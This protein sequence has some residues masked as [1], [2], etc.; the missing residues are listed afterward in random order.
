MHD[1]VAHR[2]SQVSMRAGALAYRD[3]LS[4]DQMRAESEI[5][6]DA[7]NEALRELR[8]VLQVLR[9]PSSGA[10]IDHPQPTHDD[11]A[12]LVDDA[13]RSGAH[14]ELEQEITGRV[15]TETGLTL[16]RIVQE[17][18]T[19]AS[20]HAPG[21][22]LHVRL[23]DDQGGVAVTMTNRLGFGE[24]TAPG[25]GLGLIG[26]AERFAVAGGRFEHEHRDGQFTVRA[27]VPCA[28]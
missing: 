3:D 15:P 17:G 1:V 23:I 5:I 8:S 10:P 20:K 21:A 6:R 26:L 22:R 4:V 19:N 12:A 14:V 16:Y 24:T 7:A 9:D 28:M 18:I 2:I 27:W 13:R 11:I 25:A